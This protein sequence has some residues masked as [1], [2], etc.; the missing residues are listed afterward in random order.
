MREIARHSTRMNPGAH[1]HWAVG[2]SI[3]LT[4]AECGHEQHRKLS[5][6]LPARGRVRCKECEKLRDGST[7][8]EK[9][10]DGPWIRYGWDAEQGVPT[11]TVMEDV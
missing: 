8:R 6:G 2:G 1:K 5:Q 10:G 4:L 3:S 7:P 11:R 9:R